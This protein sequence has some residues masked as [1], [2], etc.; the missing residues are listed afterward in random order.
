M[1]SFDA[2]KSDHMTTG[3]LPWFQSLALLADAAVAMS[4]GSAGKHPTF[5]QLLVELE[6]S[7]PG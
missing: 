2:L 3:T 4:S 5:A 1:H 6:P 7:A